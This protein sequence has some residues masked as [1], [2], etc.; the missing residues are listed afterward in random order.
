MN[1]LCLLLWTVL[2]VV[3]CSAQSSE[4]KS[5]RR[6]FDESG[7]FSYA[8]TVQLYKEVHIHFE[9][10]DTDLVTKSPRITTELLHADNA[11]GEDH[12]TGRSK[13]SS[14]QVTVRHEGRQ[15]SWENNPRD[16]MSVSKIMC[17]Q[18]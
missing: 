6:E 3:Q 17:I 1:V 13:G 18:R 2:V 7:A 15:I 5:V 10:E 9:V 8:G 16:K 12:G 4:L 14:V 11:G